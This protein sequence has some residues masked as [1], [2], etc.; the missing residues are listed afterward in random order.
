[1]GRSLLLIC[2]AAFVMSMLAMGSVRTTSGAQDR[3]ISAYEADVIA[4]E[5]ALSAV[6]QALPFLESRF[7]S[8]VS[9]QAVSTRSLIG[10]AGTPAPGGSA[11]LPA[12]RLVAATNALRLAA[13]GAAQTLLPTRELATGSL[14]QATVRALGGGKVEL[15]AEGA[16][17]VPGPGGTSTPHRYTVRRV[18]ARTSPLDAAI[19][20]LAPS[21]EPTFAGSY[22]I[23]GRD[24]NPATL[25][26]TGRTESDRHGIKTNAAL[27]AERL[28]SVI[29]A[30]NQSRVMGVGGA[31]DIV[32]GTPEADVNAIFD[33]AFTHPSRVALASG[34]LGTATYGTASAPAIVVRSGDLDVRGLVQGTGILVV[35][36]NLTTSGS[37]RLVWDG[38][39][40]ARK[41]GGA[42]T[43]ANLTAS[44]GRGSQVTGSYVLVQGSSALVMPFN[45]RV[46]VAYLSS[47]AGIASSVGIEHTFE[48]ALT[49]HQLVGAGANR[50]GTTPVV[51]YT[52]DLVAGQQ[53]NFFIGATQGG[54]ERYRHYARGH[55]APRSGK[56]YGVATASGAF[57]W[58]MAFE[59]IDEQVNIGYGTTP[60]WDYD[61]PGQEDQKI[62]VT[63]QCR[64]Y[65]NGALRL[66]GGVQQYE[67]CTPDNPDTRQR[68]VALSWTGLTGPSGAVPTP[69]YGTRLALSLDG[70]TL[71]HSSASIGRLAPLLQTLR[72]RSTLALVEAWS[73]R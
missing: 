54:V 13:G 25:A 3:R 40:M 66:V 30:A 37:G 11:Y 36:G 70:A 2:T 26:L 55:F 61:R 34:T 27:V 20:V 53:V 73:G 12:H 18:Y 60:D 48:D 69:A 44:L 49:R 43:D 71:L 64:T 57:G 45:A 51:Q 6:N 14:Q 1:M 24:T 68:D 72:E 59:D 4:R 22:R 42:G 23:D 8:L 41:D 65:R 21:V 67:D 50:G 63:L 7:D 5:N 9:G 29:G 58:T 62:E 47:N 10:A 38:V 15:L 52:H 39:V 32:S 35:N 31:G 17:Y 46:K 56:P 19:V 28:G 16:A 33:E